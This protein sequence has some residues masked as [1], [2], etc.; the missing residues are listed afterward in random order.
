MLK[1]IFGYIDSI[2]NSYLRKLLKIFFNDKS[3]VEQFCYSSAAVQYHH[4]YIGGLIEHTLSTV[5]LCNFI[6]ENYKEIK[7]VQKAYTHINDFKDLIVAGAIL[8]DIGKIEEYKAEKSG[9]FI[10]TSD[11]GKL[12]GH[13][14][15]GYGMVL[16][17]IS[18]IK[19]FP[20][21][22]KDRLLHI[23]LS[24]HGHKEFGSP[25][26]PKTIEAFIVYHADHLDA[27]IGG[28]S[29]A[30]ENNADGAEW[31]EYLKN[32]DR[33]VLLKEFNLEEENN[34][35]FEEQ[36]NENQVKLF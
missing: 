29:S 2:K 7:A 16:E 14:T 31:S 10:K 36:V 28:F 4:A 6:A 33:S 5:K 23:I 3:F 1:E 8:H 35:N 12:I 9:A 11:K 24:H 13:I 22:L 20:V 19:D 18:K 32:F 30:M 25:K 21:Q 26:R 15:I 34:F 27:D 17:K